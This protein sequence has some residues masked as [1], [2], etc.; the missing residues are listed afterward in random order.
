MC[1]SDS[2]EMVRGDRPRRHGARRISPRQPDLDRLVAIKELGLLQREDA[3]AVSRFLRESRMAGALSHPN[4]VTVLEFFEHDGVPVHRDGVRAARVAAAVDRA[5]DAAQVGGVL[6]G[7]LA[8]LAH[9]HAAGVIHRDLK[10]ENLLLTDGG[11]RQDR[12]L[13]DRQGA[14][15]AERRDVPHR[16][17]RRDRAR[18]PTCRPS[19]R[20]PR[21]SGPWTDLYATGVI[22]YELLSGRRPFGDGEPM[23]ILMAHAPTTR[24]RC[25]SRRRRCRAVAAWVHRLLAK[26]RADRPQTAREAWEELEE[27]LIEASARAGAGRADR[28]RAGRAHHAVARGHRA[29][30]EAPF[31]AATRAPDR[32]RPRRGHRRR[33][34]TRS[35]RRRRRRRRR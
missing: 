28:G 35:G 7:M 12:R 20:W 21:R 5:A 4:I 6:E 8:G 30:D 31:R 32:R 16:D 27:C 1:R 2:Y 24:R 33:C 23:A 10:P 29:G 9:A 17:G 11:P 26:E 13:R 14:R 22:A 15:R 25:A 19:R 34:G 18:R 3:D